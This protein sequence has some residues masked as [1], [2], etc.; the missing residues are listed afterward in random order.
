MLR[1][2]VA[3]AAAALVIQS[4]PARALASVETD[5]AYTKT[6]TYNAALRYLR[7]D[8]GYEVVEKDPDAAYLLFRFA[9]QGKKAPSNGAIE[10]V[11]QRAG[12]RVR[13][14]IRL[15]ELPHFHEQMLSDGLFEKLRNEYGDPPR[16]DDPPPKEKDKD[17][18]GDGKN[19]GKN[20]GKNDGKAKP[21]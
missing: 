3:F 1:S 18:Q 20:D 11:D 6:Q 12:D 19:N 13:V 4:V 15:P 5:T 7:V 16:H 10:I 8:L 2:V 14:Y 9:A 21:D 17:G